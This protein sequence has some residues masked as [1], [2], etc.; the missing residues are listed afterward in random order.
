[1]ASWIAATP[2]PGTHTLNGT[3]PLITSQPASRTNGATTTA[4]FSV[5]ASGSAPLFYQWRANGANV[6]GATNATLILPN[7]QLSDAGTYQAVVFNGAGSMDSSNALLTVRV[8]PTITNQPTNF[9]I[10][11]APDPLG[12]PTNR[13]TFSV[14]AVTYSPPL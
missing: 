7:L 8:G 13:A 12:S 10:R 9:F 6:D 1:P 2:T 4:S 3:A 14:A 5:N 11:V